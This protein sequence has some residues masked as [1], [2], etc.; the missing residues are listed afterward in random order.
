MARKKAAPK[1]KVGR[2][3]VLGLTLEES[4]TLTVRTTQEQILE[5]QRAAVHEDMGVS[6]FVRRAV[7]DAVRASLANPK[8]GSGEKEK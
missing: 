6:A 7:F 3:R 5:I 8:K 4:K 1:K 2:P